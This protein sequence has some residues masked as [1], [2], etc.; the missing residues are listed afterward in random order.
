V[1]ALP[2]AATAWGLAL[3][4]SGGLIFLKSVRH[5]SLII[6]SLFAIVAVSALPFTPTWDGAQLYGILQFDSLS[7]LRTLSWIMFIVY[8]AAHALLLL[9]YAKHALRVDEAEKIIERWVWIIYPVGLG[10][11]PLT[12]FGITWWTGLGISGTMISASPLSWALGWWGG[13]LSLG[14]LGMMILWMRRGPR[15]PQVVGSSLDRLFSLEWFYRILWWL[16]RTI[17]RT[18]TVIDRVFE[19]DGG[20]LWALLIV[21][22]LLAFLFARNGG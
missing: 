6:L 15:I 7:G 4:F 1:L 18:V 12:H 17:S 22:L 21:T 10:V 20:L 19:G 5:R 3:L 14:L 13:L 2:E 11:L 16:Y 8:A 9:G